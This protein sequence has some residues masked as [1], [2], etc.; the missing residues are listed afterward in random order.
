MRAGGRSGGGGMGGPA[1]GDRV[2]GELARYVL[3]SE[4]D[5]GRSRGM[6][7]AWSCW[8]C[9][10]LADG[11]AR[12]QRDRPPRS[13][14]RVRRFEALPPARRLCSV[15][16]GVLRAPD[17]LFRSRCPNVPPSRDRVKV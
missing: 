17:A 10:V 14:V 15:A 5:G 3:H 8:A 6:V 1:L 13:G 9:S 16:R 4:G 2:G 7:S 12:P 11:F